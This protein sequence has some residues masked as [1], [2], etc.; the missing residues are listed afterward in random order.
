MNNIRRQNDGSRVVAP[1][2]DVGGLFHMRVYLLYPN[3][4]QLQQG[5]RSITRAITSYRIEMPL[6]ALEDKSLPLS[7]L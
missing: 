6:A 7:S 5:I 2:M 4:L 1:E 3:T